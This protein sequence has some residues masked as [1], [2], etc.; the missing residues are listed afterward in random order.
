MHFSKENIPTANRYLKRCST[1]LILREMLIKTTMGYH[2]TPVRMA[3]FFSGLTRQH[4]GSQFP[5]QGSKP[6]P[7][8]WECRI[9]ATGL[10]EKSPEGPLF[11]KSTNNKCWRKGNPP[12][13]LVEMQI[14]AATMENSMKQFLKKQKQSYHL[15]L[16]SHS[17]AY[18][19]RKL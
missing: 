3:F 8:H 1:L 17:W 5:K 15:I 4:A 16:Q 11:K 14:S 2:L 18:I 13:L 7:L 9:L 6:G 12:T 10:S 19:W